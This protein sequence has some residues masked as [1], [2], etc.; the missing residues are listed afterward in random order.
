MFVHGMMTIGCLS[1]QRS[2]IPQIE[3][4]QVK[5]VKLDLPAEVV[6]DKPFTIPGKEKPAAKISAT[7]PEEPNTSA[8]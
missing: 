2:T 5:L 8:V 7:M 4:L 1:M 6:T 3:T